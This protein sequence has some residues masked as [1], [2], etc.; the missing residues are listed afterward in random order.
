[1]QMSYQ[2]VVATPFGAL[3][4]RM[5]SGALTAI[6]FLPARPPSCPTVNEAAADV[7]AQLTRYLDNPHHPFDFPLSL[8]GTPFQQSVWHALQAIP[9]GETVTYA[10][11]AQRLSSGPRAVANAC[12]ANPIPVVIPCHRVVA[13]GGLGGFMKGRE[14]NSLSIKQW[15]L[16]HERGQSSIAG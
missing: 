15:L 2:A 3:G 10:E 1:M 8:G 5:Q 6:D 7:T 9:V 16:A 11:L 13:K 14:T 4:V 12:G